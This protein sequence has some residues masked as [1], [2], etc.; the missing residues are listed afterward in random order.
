VANAG[1]GVDIRRGATLD[2]FDDLQ[3]CRRANQQVSAEELEFMPCRP[4]CDVKIAA[5]S[6]GIDR[7]TDHILDRSHRGEIDD[8][9]YFPRY[10]RKTMARPKEHYRRSVQVLRHESAEKG[11][12]HQP[13]LLRAQVAAHGFSAFPVNR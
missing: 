5:K 9:D 12:D 4:P 13:S 7:R 2:S 6:Q 3:P 11:F 10:V 1:V 8:R